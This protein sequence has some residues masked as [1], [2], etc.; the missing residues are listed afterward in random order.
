M[1]GHRPTE[2]PAERVLAQ[3]RP[4]CGHYRQPFTPVRPHQRFCRP[5]CRIQAF[6]ARQEGRA[7]QLFE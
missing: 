3:N 6:K 7:G 1:N 4:L 5:S 2:R